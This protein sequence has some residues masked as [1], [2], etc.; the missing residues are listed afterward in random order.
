MYEY[1]SLVCYKGADIPFQCEDSC[2]SGGRVLMV[3]PSPWCLQ[4]PWHSNLVR[5]NL[6]LTSKDKAEFP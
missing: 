6:I 1:G 5:R 2:N 3:V 4:K